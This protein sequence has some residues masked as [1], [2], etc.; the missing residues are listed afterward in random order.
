VAP[1]AIALGADLCTGEKGMLAAPIP[2]ELSTSE[3]AGEIEVFARAARRAV[4]AAFDG[5]ELHGANG[6]L[7]Q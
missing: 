2:R 4:D 1:C 3:V 7:I 6:Y 5:V